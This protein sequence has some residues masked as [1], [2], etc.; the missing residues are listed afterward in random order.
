MHTIIYP[1]EKTLVI[2]FV[3]MDVSAFKGTILAKYRFSFRTLIHSHS[4][5]S[6]YLVEF[7]LTL[8]LNSDGSN[9]GMKTT[10][11]TPP[12]LP[13]PPPPFWIQWAP[14]W[15]EHKIPYIVYIRFIL[16]FTYIIRTKNAM[17]HVCLALSHTLRMR[18]C[19][20]FDCSLPL[21]ASFLNKICKQ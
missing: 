8:L 7:S 20:S 19:V 2:S 16:A 14:L 21:S 5:P 9:S 10:T 17:K 15:A 4:Q 6:K 3:C 11:T 1:D 18:V 12:S 13:L